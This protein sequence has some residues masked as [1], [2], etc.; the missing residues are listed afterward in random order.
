MQC[1]YLY[2]PYAL[3]YVGSH[4][5]TIDLSNFEANIFAMNIILTVLLSKEFTLT[6]PSFPYVA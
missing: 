3:H 2:L 1:M 6:I 4:K 5:F